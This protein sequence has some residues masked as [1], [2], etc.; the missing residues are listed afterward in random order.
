MGWFGPRGLASIV[1]ALVYL[2][3][4][5]G[6]AGNSTPTCGDGDGAVQHLRAWPDRAARNK[7]V[8]KADRGPRRDVSRAPSAGGWFTRAAAYAAGR[9]LSARE[10]PRV[11]QQRSLLCGRQLHGCIQPRYHP[12]D[13]GT[14]LTGPATQLVTQP[15]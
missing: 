11:P 1:L 12:M 15:P 9:H 2:V 5:A 6:L 14:P 8:C 7:P 10:R 4:E 3:R 13:P